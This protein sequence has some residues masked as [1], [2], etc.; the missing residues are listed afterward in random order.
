M[1]V[2]DPDNIRLAMLGMVE[3]NG[4]PFSWSAII[5]GDYDA[6]AMAACGYPVIP[7][8]LGAQPREAL[9]IP[10]AKVTHVWCDDPADAARVAEASCVPNVAARAEDVIGEVDAVLIATD[11]GSEHV[12]RARPFVEAGLPVFVD[13]PLADNAADLRQF[14]AWQAAGKAILSSSCMRYAK[15]FAALRERMEDIGEARL[16]T[17]TMAKSV[18]RYGIHAIEAVYPFLAAGGHMAVTHT[19]TP[20]RDLLRVAHESGVETVMAV[21]EDLYGAFGHVQVYGTEG[22]DGA[23]F[24]DT[25]FAFKAQL[26]AYVNY[27][28]TGVAPFPF[29]ETVEQIRILIAALVSRE[30]GGR[31]VAL[32]DVGV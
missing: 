29:E 10:G 22:A 7:E 3:G 27:L 17:V 6:Q 14:M 15:E 24:Q 4:H 9:G 11:I 30:A 28:R 23:V 2:A 32:T 5:N 1:K 21:M 25:F 13:K 8:Y 20:G 18:E 19:G 31:P 26:E 12:E 16:I